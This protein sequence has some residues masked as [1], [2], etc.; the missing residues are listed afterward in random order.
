M[1][2]IKD[3]LPDW[4][5]FASQKKLFIF[6]ILTYGLIPLQREQ[7]QRTRGEPGRHYLLFQTTDKETPPTSTK[8]RAKAKRSFKSIILFPHFTPLH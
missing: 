1:S 5:S 7:V 6:F 4:C 8:T 3:L 2:R